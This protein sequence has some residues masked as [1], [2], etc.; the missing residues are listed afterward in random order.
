[1]LSEMMKN[2][3]H[4][5]KMHIIYNLKLFS[6]EWPSFKKFTF[7]SKGVLAQTNTYFHSLFLPLHC[8]RLVFYP[9]LSH[10]IDNKKLWIYPHYS[11]KQA[12]KTCIVGINFIFF[13]FFNICILS[14]F[15]SIIINFIFCVVSFLRVIANAENMFIRRHMSTT[16]NAHRMHSF[17][18]KTNVYKNKIYIFMLYLR[19]I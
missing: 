14:Q 9:V 19:N 4:H 5:I 7:Q 16:S 10:F 17:L 8:C 12:T 15:V 3:S 11:R 1:M 6:G 2:G 13:F 18:Q